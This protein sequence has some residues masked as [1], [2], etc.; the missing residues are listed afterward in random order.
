MFSAAQ[1]LRALF[2]FT[3][4]AVSI[5]ARA[6]YSSS[7]VLDSVDERPTLI[8]GTRGSPLALAQVCSF[9]KCFLIFRRM[10]LN[11]V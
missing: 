11:V 10:K 1:M 2:V 5:D 9:L 3:L 4:A 7:D 6:I 8:I